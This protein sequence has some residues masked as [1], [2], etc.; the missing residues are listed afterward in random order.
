MS[1]GLKGARV[2]LFAPKFFNYENNIKDE[3]ESQG[4]VVHLYD[5]RNNPTSVEKILFR[6]AHFLMS[7]KVNKFYNSIAKK[8]KSFNPD[9]V[10]FVNPE[11]V[12]KQSLLVLKDSFK[13]ARFIIYM[14]DSCKNKNVKHLFSLFDAAF[15]FD[16]DDCEKYGL[17]FRPLFF[18]PTFQGAETEKKEYKY[19]VSFIGTVHSDRAKILYHIKQYCDE[20]GLKYYFYLYIPGKLMYILRMALNKYLRKF[21]RG[22]IHIVSIDKSIVADVSDNSRCIIDI[23]HPRQTGL[24]MRTLEMLGLKRKIITTNENICKYDFYNPA[25]QIVIRRTDFSISK[26]MILHKYEDIPDEI[27][28]KYSLED[29]VKDIFGIKKNSFLK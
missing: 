20:H 25:D 3:I 28:T 1:A 7:N 8:E 15:S 21:S 6:K 19:D 17:N 16:L 29:W 23:N 22:Y 27:H 26:D 18:V 11:T 12:N 10:V 4:A 2:L 9:Y 24:T 13:N 14:W 5:E